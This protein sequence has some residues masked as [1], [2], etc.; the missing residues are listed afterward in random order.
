MKKGLFLRVFVYF[1]CISFLL[2]TNS[3]H[4]VIAEAKEMDRPIG[5]IFSK[6]EVKFE[7]KKNVWKRVEPYHFPI[8]QGV[9]VKTERGEALIRLSNDTHI[10][11][12]PNTLLSFDQASRADL[13]NGSINFRVKPDA[14]IN[15]KVGQL[16]ISNSRPLQA[17]KG[18]ASP[19]ATEE[20]I[21]SISIHSSGAVTVKSLQGSIS[22]LDQSRVVIA[23]LSSKD[24]VT[25]PSVTV[26]SPPKAMVA[27]AGATGSGKGDNDDDGD[28]TVYWIIGGVLAAGAAG[29]GIWALANRGD[30]GDGFFFCRP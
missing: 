1:L 2:L 18:G 9:K 19:L 11:L 14:E 23:A 24:S 12:N 30:G 8:F 27:Q 3:F 10:E 28:N 16:S 20:T 6:G 29:V 5:E 25:V 4:Y 21:G 17:S 15:F 22:I 26:K 7:V 13:F